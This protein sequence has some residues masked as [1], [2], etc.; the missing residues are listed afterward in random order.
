MASTA[1]ITLISLKDSDLVL[2]HA[3]DDVRG[4]PVVDPHGHR[5]GEVDDLVIDEPGHR[6]R[7]LVV[8][9]GGLLG[10]GQTSHLLP[11]DAVTRVSDEVH[12]ETPHEQVHRAGPYT[13]EPVS[14][15]LFDQVYRYFGYVPF[16][17]P[18]YVPPYF[19][20]RR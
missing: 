8:T 2:A 6:V 9:S 17:A 12:V 13:P 16:W 20:R 1:A 19:H 18:D 15:P 11:I 5:L 3:A 7:L 14:A 10:L 4:L